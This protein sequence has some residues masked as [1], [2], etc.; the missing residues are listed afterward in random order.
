M[1]ILI[2]FFASLLS[3]AVAQTIVATTPPFVAQLYVPNVRPFCYDQSMNRSNANNLN[4]FQIVRPRSMIMDM[5]GDVLVTSATQSRI[6]AIRCMA[7]T[8]F[9]LNFMLE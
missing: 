4:S 3:Y 2:L 5:A 9:L 1:K 7:Y 6:T 8:L